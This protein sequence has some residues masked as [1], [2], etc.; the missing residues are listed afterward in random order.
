M[1]WDEMLVW[2][3]GRESWGVS[4]VWREDVGFWAVVYG[5]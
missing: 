5:L 1:S 3:M 2:V 4:G